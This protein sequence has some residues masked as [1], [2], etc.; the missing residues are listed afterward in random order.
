MHT[1]GTIRRWDADKGFG[2][3]QGATSSNVFFHIRDFRGG[4]P[5]E[6]MPVEY[7]EIQVGGKGP[8]A[9]AVRPVQ[10][11]AAVTA[12][13]RSATKSPEPPAARRP[14]STTHRRTRPQPQR[15]APTGASLA[16]VLMLGWLALLAWG[17]WTQRLPLWLPGAML[18]LN[19]LTFLSYKLDKSAA[20]R[21]SW[22]TS[23]K[24]L[25][26]LALLGGWPAAWW[27]QQTLRHKSSKEVFRR[28]YWGTMLLNCAA[29]GLLVLR[30]D[31]LPI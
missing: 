2:F 8:R 7:E 24:Q 12:G 30:P 21:G 3:I 28:T 16:K 29:L 20:Q 23:E 4:M 13:T 6:G 1:Q 17:A 22:R 10:T 15:D 25:H 26:L 31:L 5:A 9:M 19:L 27:A 14:S 18:G 11:H